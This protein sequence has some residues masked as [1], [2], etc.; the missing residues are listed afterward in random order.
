MNDKIQIEVVKKGGGRRDQAISNAKAMEKGAKNTAGSMKEA[1]NS[2]KSILTNLK[3]AFNRTAVLGWGAVI[4]E[5]VNDLINATKPQSEYV[6]NINLMN[7]AFGES[8]DMANSFI[9]SLSNVIG[10]DASPLTR[11]IG[12]FRQMSNAMGYTAETADMLSRN[13]TKMQLDMASLYNLDFER[14]GNAL[15]SA[16]TGQVKTIRSL[17]GAD[18]TQATLQQYALAHGIDETVTK[19][20]R[21]EKAILIYLSLA[22][23]MAEANGDLSRTIDSV[24]NQ[25][26]IFKEQVAIAGR[27]LGGV[28]IP[29]LRTVLPILNGILMAFNQIIGMF[30]SLFGIDAKSLEAEF[31]T[32]SGGLN[33]IEDGLEGIE[34]ASKKSKK[35]LRGF[36]KLNNITTPSSSGSASGGGL[37]IN[38]KLLDLLDEYN[39]HLDGIHSKAKKI[40]EQIMRWL[41]F[42][43]DTNGE[44]KWSVE[45]L[46]GLF[47]VFKD[48]EE[49][50]RHLKESIKEFASSTV[51]DAFERMKEPLKII[52][53]MFMYIGEHAI[54]DV[55]IPV[56]GLVIEKIADIFDD[57]N[58]Y[59]SK[60]GEPIMTTLTDYLSWVNEKLQILWEKTLKPIFDIILDINRTIWKQLHPIVEKLWELLT[61]IFLIIYEYWKK[62][63]RPIFDFLIDYIFPVITNFL[64]SLWE[65]QLK[66]LFEYIGGSIRN[67]IDVVTNVLKIVRGLITGD[68]NL[69][70]DGIKGAINAI[71]DQFKNAM[72]YIGN[73]FPNAIKHAKNAWEGIKTVFSAVPTWFET[74]FKDAWARVK[75]IFSAGGKIF[76][77]IK[78]GISDT[79]KS[80]VN[81]LIKGIN[82]II[83]TPFNKINDMLNTIRSVD[84]LGIKP[85]KNLWSKNPLSVPVIP[86]LKDGGFLDEGQMFIAREAGPEMVGTIG[87]RT[88]VA[89]NDQI[90]EAIS[91]GVAKAMKSATPTERPVQIIAEGD[92]S[93]LMDFITFKQQQKDRQ[94]GL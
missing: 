54:K 87:G 12:V 53:E 4:K 89:N 76:D 32:A 19:M 64:K 42:S 41:G 6:E 9:E 62:H 93:G 18:I 79:F 17:T 75:N 16:L 65:T 85:F 50:A 86:T 51:L 74:K 60:Y 66:P 11:Q 30:L 91:I 15:E 52:R 7:V 82:K 43:K 63:I 69:I 83:S 92:A 39:L 34:S 44:W 67:I 61:E 72:N 40:A 3:E 38:Q 78:E 21:A 23:Q 73:L 70:K 28:F 80:I 10:L 84:V 5:T 58:T 1:S 57:I 20:T 27:Q 77:G 45:N 55:L 13:L 48:L 29:L 22:D 46:S 33:D 8:Q 25:V 26:K 56:I 59:W 71:T 81:A 94:Y 49:P 14:A 36:D 88:A 31:G 37:G 2:S 68:T 90:V 47:K 24:S 35:S